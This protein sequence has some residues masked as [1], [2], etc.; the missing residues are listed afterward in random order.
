MKRYYVCLSFAA[1][2]LALAVASAQ[3][4]RTPSVADRVVSGSPFAI[5]ADAEA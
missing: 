3:T 5:K 2:V 1:G 4:A